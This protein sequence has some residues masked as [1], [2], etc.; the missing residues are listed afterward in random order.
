[1]DVTNYDIV[2]PICL[3]LLIVVSLGLGY[4]L[5]AGKAY[6]KPGK[7]GPCVHCGR[8]YHDHEA[9]L[10]RDSINSAS[11]VR[12]LMKSSCSTSTSGT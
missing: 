1:M 8:D 11:M 4:D 12:S 6:V 9:S 2:L 5:W 7:F 10:N 3:A